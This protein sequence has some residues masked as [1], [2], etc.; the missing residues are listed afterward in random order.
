[1]K[2]ALLSSIFTLMVC[3]PSFAQPTLLWES[4]YHGAI[5]DD[6]PNAMTVDDEGNVYVTGYTDTPSETSDYL[7]IKYNANGDIVWARTYNGAA[8][9]DDVAHGLK[10]DASGNVYVTGQSQ[11]AGDGVNMVTIKYNAAGFQQW[12]AVHSGATNSINI[13]YNIATDVFGNV[14]AAGGNSIN[15]GVLVK[16]NASGTAQWTSDLAGRYENEV[17]VLIHPNDGNII[18]AGGSSLISRFYLMAVN[19]SDGATV[20]AYNTNA[21]QYGAGFPNALVLDGIGNM[22]VTSTSNELGGSNPVRV[23]TTKFIY[24][25]TNYQAYAWRSYSYV[26]DSD[27]PLL[28][29]AGMQLDNDNN[30][31]VAMSFYNGS[32]YTFSLRKLSP[33]GATIW[34]SPPSGAVGVEGTPVAM[35]LS[36]LSDPPDI[37]VAGYD[38]VGDFKTVKYS[39][40]DG[41]VLWT[42]TYDCG[43]SGADIATTMVVD[44]CDNIYIAGTSSCSG[45]FKDVKTIKFAVAAPPDV[46][47]DGPTT[48]CQGGSVT[49]TAEEGDTYLWSND[50][51]MRSITVSTSGSYTVTV[52]NAGGCPQAS[53]P[54]EVTVV[55]PPTASIAPAGVV[56]VCENST[57]VLT[58]SPA[59]AYLWSNGATTPSITVTEAGDYRVTVTNAAGC[60]AVSAFTTVEFV[61]APTA[62]VSPPGPFEICQGNSAILTAS[63][64]STYRWNTGATTPS[65]TVT[66]AGPYQVTVTNTNGCS[67]VSEATMVAVLSLPTAAITPD[68]EVEFCQGSSVTLNADPANTYLWSNGETTPSITVSEPGEYVVTVTSAAGCTAVS[69]PTT[70]IGVPAPVTT[71][72]PVGDLEFCEGGSVVLQASQAD[73]YLWNTEETSQVIVADAG[74]DYSVTVTNAAGCSGDASIT[75]T[76]WPVAT[77][78]LMST[79]TDCGKTNGRILTTVSGGSPIESFMWSN[80]D[81]M[82]LLFDLPGGVYSVTATDVNGCTATAEATVVGRVNPIVTIDTVDLGQQFEL[83]AIATGSGLTYSW[84]SGGNTPSITVNTSGT[85]TVTVTNSQGCSASAFEVIVSTSDKGIKHQ[86]TIFPNPATD[87]LYIK[88]EGAPTA[89]VRLLN[90]LGKQLLEDRTLM[91]DGATRTLRLDN[92]PPGSYFIE[93]VG[94]DFRR[95]LPFVKTG[96]R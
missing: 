71:I 47:P 12:A 20:R 90:V 4:A 34:R 30:V 84:S 31:Y 11:G 88:C 14:Y 62:T 43:N 19:P 42:K 77:L 45:T 39:N 80:G 22:Y 78:S 21:F 46:T 72:T 37:Y 76:E 63:P 24:P 5:A 69:E 73:S 95:A 55:P 26:I 2:N 92:V 9:G 8:N 29:G 28:S 15:G 70:L 38:A 36:N 59:S 82:Q 48:F 81:T 44:N 74:G 67:A 16:Y 86:I 93:V 52:T 6:Q 33:N 58:A 83:T 54:V 91:P 66:E 32:F 1:M 41:N 68:G 49:L 17:L 96:S 79:D 35:A 61:P 64:A 23:E 40:A 53:L 56:T 75:V 85:Y 3:I 25:G 89:S 7:T 13:G 51:T 60:T 94:R 50:A 27:G 18:V 10:V 57:A 87:V 65:I